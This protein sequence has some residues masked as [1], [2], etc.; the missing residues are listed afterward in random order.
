VSR[1]I[2]GHH[3]VLYVQE[4]PENVKLLKDYIIY[5]DTPLTDGLN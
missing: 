5:I 3:Y 2:D 4:T 1:D